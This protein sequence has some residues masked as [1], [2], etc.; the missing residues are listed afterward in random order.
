MSNS[1]ERNAISSIALFPFYTY[2]GGNGRRQQIYD[3]NNNNKVVYSGGSKFG[4]G[5]IIRINIVEGIHG[6]V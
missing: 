4:D 5:E 1:V 2:T 3:R 6:S